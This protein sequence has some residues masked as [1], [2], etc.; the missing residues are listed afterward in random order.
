MSPFQQQPAPSGM[1]EPPPTILIV[2][3]SLDGRQTLQ[4]LLA[5][6]GYTLAFAENGFEGL[7]KA[8][9]LVPD[10]ILLDVMLPGIDGLE[11][12]RRIRANPLL[13]EVPIMMVTALEDRDTRLQG[14][15][16]GADDFISKRFDGTELRARVRTIT[17]LN[18]YRRLVRERARFERLVHL[19]PNGLLLVDADGAI[20]LVNPAML[21]I[22]R[23]EQPEV[24]Q[25]KALWL[26]IEPEQ[27][28][29]CAA[30]LRQA[31]IDPSYSAQFETECLRVDGAP[32][33]AEM[34]V[35]HFGW[36]EQPLAYVVIRDITTRRCLEAQL[37]Q[38]QKMESIGRLAGGIAHDFNNLI[39][40]IMGYAEMSLDTLPPDARER[41]DLIAIST[42]ARS[43]A[44]LTRQLLAF[45][46]RQPIQPQVF[47]PNDLL[48]EIDRLLRRL[49]GEDIELVVR[50]DLDLGLVRADPGQ[51]EQVL[52]NLAVNARDAMPDGGRLTIETA[53]VLL[54]EDYARAHIGVA[55]GQYV[56]LAVTDTGV[57]MDESIKNYIFEPFFTTKS[58]GH[59]TGLGLA[60]CYGIIQQHGG[61]IEVDSEPLQGT[62]FKIYLPRAESESTGTAQPED[63]GTILPRGAE[64]ILLVE[65]EP[66]IRTLVVRI[67]RDLGYTV[68]ATGDGEEALRAARAYASAP[69]DL[70]LTDVVMP[71]LG[72]KP[73]ADHMTMLYPGIKVLF[74]S[75]YAE[76]ALAQHGRLEQDV[77]F[78]SKPF[79]AAALARKVRD[80]LDRTGPVGNLNDR[81]A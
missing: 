13:A 36:D 32:F 23:A 50:P 39:T 14:I 58:P 1:R 25:G 49:I 64:R 74:T 52:V 3:D 24:V 15:I 51:I 61:T 2:E 37:L 31:A 9:E 76:G 45:A 80:V 4:T 47:S 10:L 53:N 16:A 68:L 81:T 55:P 38:S 46:R 43:A 78:L 22:L 33:P 20:S 56:M 26:W 40:A 28:D 19:M 6:Q 11:V 54:D 34:E 21:G 5:G 79:T 18:R 29:R 69:F 63:T 7:A 70:L 57:G 41:E 48:T 73:L 60:T 44:N 42:S 27:R 66:D 62:A 71:K 65:D 30:C 77:A 75:G 12:C 35:G 72:G 67:L 8:T 17:R 59:G